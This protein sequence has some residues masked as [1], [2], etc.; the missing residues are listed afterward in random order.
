MENTWQCCNKYV[1]VEDYDN[2]TSVEM[3]SCD[4]DVM[5]GSIYNKDVTSRSIRYQEQSNMFGEQSNVLGHIVGNSTCQ[6]QSNPR[7]I[8]SSSAARHGD[9]IIQLFVGSPLDTNVKKGQIFR[10]SDVK[11]RLFLSTYIVCGVSILLENWFFVQ[12]K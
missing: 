1:T 10:K 8:S 9:L 6:T 11:M 4:P 12:L 5:N 2:C 7:K 3:V